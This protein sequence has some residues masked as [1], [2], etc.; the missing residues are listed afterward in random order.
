[1]NKKLLVVSILVVFTLVA[2]SYASA[3]SS[4]TPI[5]KKESPLFGIRTRQAIKEKIGDVIENI[6]AKYIGERVFFLP[7]R[8]TLSNND[9][10]VRQIIQ[11][12]ILTLID[13]TVDCWTCT[14]PTYCDRTCTDNTWYCRTCYDTACFC[15]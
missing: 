7:F 2:I 12:K 6:K 15:P 3:F 5:K 4:Y 11:D 8:F 1:M 14:G 9:L 13:S 10:L